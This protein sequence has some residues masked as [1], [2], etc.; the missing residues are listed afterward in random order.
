[1]PNGV[2]GSLRAKTPDLRVNEIAES[3]GGGGHVAAAGCVINESIGDAKELL[4]RE[5]YELWDL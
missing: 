1:M 2:K 4:E 3:F 5:I